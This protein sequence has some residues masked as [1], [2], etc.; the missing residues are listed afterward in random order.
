[1]NY[2]NIKYNDIANGEGI[3]VSLFVIKGENKWERL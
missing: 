1:M 2:A 3:S